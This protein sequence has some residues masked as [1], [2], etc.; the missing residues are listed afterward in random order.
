MY[1]EQALVGKSRQEVTRM[2]IV[3]LFATTLF[4]GVC[5]IVA[6]RQ[7]RNGKVGAILMLA[8]LY[9]FGEL[10]QR[11]P[12][13]FPRFLRWYL[14]DFG[15]TP[16]A[17]V[18]AYCL[19]AGLGSR[20]PVRSARI[21][22]EIAVSIVAALEIISMRI[23]RGDPVDLFMYVAAM[24]TTFLLLPRPSRKSPLTSHQA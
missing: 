11:F 9:P 21:M 1:C 15:F 20:E 14:S 8:M 18:I 23:G 4:F 7:Y 5:A 13:D 10:L 3:L 6:L 12:A 22:M 19:F 17:W 2:V 16:F 24:T